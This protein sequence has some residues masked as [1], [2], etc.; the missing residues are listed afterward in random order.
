MLRYGMARDQVL[1]LEVVIASGQILSDLAPLPKN[2]S[3]YDLK[4]IF[5]GSEG[6]LGLITAACLKLRP[7]PVTRA[8]ACVGLSTLEDVLT[9]FGRARGELAEALTAFEMMPRA[10][11]GL[12]FARTNAAREPFATRTPWIV[13]LEAESASQYFDLHRA[14]DALLE[15]A[16]SEGIVRDGT[17]ATN[18]A[19]RRDLWALRE[20]IPLAMIETRASLKSDT[21][22]PI[23][24]IPDFVRQANKAVAAI[25]PG[26]IAVPFGHVGDGNIHFNV[27]PPPAMPEADFVHCKPDLVRAIDRI[28]LALGGT[29]SAEHG[30]G[31]LR[32]E[33]LKEMKSRQCLDTMRVLKI[34]LDPLG[35][36]NPGKIF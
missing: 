17:I 19:Q 12:Q 16:I 15:V 26:C 24:A 32:R 7:K 5:I 2:N 9:L 21:A 13:L 18:E 31:L 6:T 20:G 33:G 1:G 36:F 25:V 4:Q 29:I 28:T 23:A 22:V 35:L 14:I 34:A 11:L 10:G 30:I 8:T 27:L 3:G